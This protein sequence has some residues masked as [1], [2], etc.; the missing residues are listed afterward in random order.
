MRNG[1]YE[2][3]KRLI[4][5]YPLTSRLM[6]NDKLIEHVQC[7]ETFFTFETYKFLIGKRDTRTVQT[8]KNKNKNSI[9]SKEKPHMHAF[10]LIINSKLEIV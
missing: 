8:L 3:E 2:F 6:S 9:K 5:N 10:K 7:I 1:F 4:L